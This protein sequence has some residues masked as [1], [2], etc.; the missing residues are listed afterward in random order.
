MCAG[1]LNAETHRC[2]NACP[3]CYILTRENVLKLLSAKSIQLG[4]VDLFIKTAQIGCSMCWLLCKMW[5]SNQE[6]EQHIIC[7]FAIRL[8]VFTD[9]SSW[10]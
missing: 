10:G 8:T 1:D 5:D 9:L 3:V 4:T 7:S 6:V 2:I